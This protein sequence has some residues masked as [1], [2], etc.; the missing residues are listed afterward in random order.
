MAEFSI[1]DNCVQKVGIFVDN[2]V[3]YFSIERIYVGFE[4]AKWAVAIEKD[5][6]N[7]YRE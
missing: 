6:P 5:R 2:C 4:Y 7:C 1:L 3:R